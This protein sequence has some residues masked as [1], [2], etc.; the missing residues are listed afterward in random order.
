[1]QAGPPCLWSV[2]DIIH[3]GVNN[4]GYA[5]LE[6]MWADYTVLSLVRN[7]YDRAGSA[8][9]YILGHRQV[10]HVFTRVWHLDTDSRPVAGPAKPLRI[11]SVG[12]VLRHGQWHLCHDPPYPQAAATPAQTHALAFLSEH[13]RVRPSAVCG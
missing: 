9:D 8:Y 10:C 4:L 13:R 6:A 5:S 12:N 7:P 11:L 2:T 3:A 1:M